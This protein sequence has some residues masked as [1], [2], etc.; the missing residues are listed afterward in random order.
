MSVI[1]AAVCGAN[2]DGFMIT[3]FP[4]LRRHVTQKHALVCTLS[5]YFFKSML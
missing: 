2:S 5:K 3:V 4:E 1:T